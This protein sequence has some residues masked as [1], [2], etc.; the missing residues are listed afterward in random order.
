MAAVAVKIVSDDWVAVIS[1]EGKELTKICA[2][3]GGPVGKITN[4]TINGNNITITTERSTQ[5]WEVYD[6]V[7]NTCKTKHIRNL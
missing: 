3:G 1:D 2:G 6:V 5:L 7:Y 4:A